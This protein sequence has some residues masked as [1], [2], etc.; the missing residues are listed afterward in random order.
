MAAPAL[1]RALDINVLEAARERIAWTF[2]AFPRI[3]LSGPMTGIPE[4]NF[5]LFDWATGLLREAGHEVFSPAE[6]DRANGFDPKGMTGTE[7]LAA[8]GFD[9]RLALGADLAWI[10][11]KAEAVALLP[12]WEN[13]HGA[14]AEIATARALNIPVRSVDQLIWEAFR[15]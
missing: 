3:Y 1:K 8:S 13:S 4:F 6:K 9:L 5:P 2:D 15:A 11:A 12:G 14:A 10:C 7:A